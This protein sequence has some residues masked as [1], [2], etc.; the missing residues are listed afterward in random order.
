MGER[1]A[2][3]LPERE[4]LLTNRWLAPLGSRMTAAALWSGRRRP[5]SRGVAAGLFSAFALP[6]GQIPLAVAIAI[7][8]RANIVVAAT[9]TMITNLVTFPIIYVVAHRLGTAMLAATQTSTARAASSELFVGGVVAPLATGLLL[10]AVVAAAV[11]YVITNLVW[12]WR[13]RA[14]RSR[15]QN[16]GN[17][18]STGRSGQM[19]KHHASINP[20][21]SARN[22]PGS[23]SRG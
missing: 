6:L 2:Y 21:R 23:N 16:A 7:P 22:Q 14:R 13:V 18:N 5:V 9:S 12:V 11:G 4:R 19:T 20:A 17:A 8:L 10:L 3:W 1:L 15:R